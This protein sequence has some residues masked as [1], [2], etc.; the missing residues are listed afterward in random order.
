MTNMTPLIDSFVNQLNEAIAIGQAAQLTPATNAIHN[1]VI[2]GL[3]GSGIGGTI[4]AELATAQCPV[5]ITVIK[6]YF[7]PAF[8][9]ANTL[10]IASSYSGNTEETLQSLEAAHS[11]G[12]KVVCVTSG[13]KVAEFAQNHNLDLITIPGGMPPR[14]CLGY[15]ISQLF[16]VLRFNG[17]VGADF[18]TNLEAAPALLQAENAAIK[19]EAEAIANKLVG[20]LPIIYT[21]P[22]FEGVAVRFRQ[23]LNENSKILCW[24]HVV[25][26]MNHNELVGWTTPDP[27]QSVIFLRSQNEY[28]RNTNRIDYCKNLIAQQTPNVIDIWT[29]GNN[30]VA[31]C[32]Y[33]VNLTDYVSD[34]LA[35]LRGVDAVEVN[36]IAGLKNM[37]AGS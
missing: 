5:P 11:K 9:G 10:F 15:S 22:G 12:A 4:I 37:L 8:V 2:A 14:A 23:Q 25:P 17:L 30:P 32:F 13:G 1:V 18:V 6:E 16:Y 28:V 26:E 31:E 27:K 29:K 20:Q 21:T 36:V 34:Y 24:H 33:L 35:A 7:I 19:T 3:G